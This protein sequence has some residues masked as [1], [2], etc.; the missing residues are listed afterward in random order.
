MALKPESFF[1]VSGQAEILRY[2]PFAILH[3]SFVI[4][5]T[6]PRES[7]TNDKCKMANEK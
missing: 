7:M 3:L 2:F 1:A 5:G 4:A 6:A